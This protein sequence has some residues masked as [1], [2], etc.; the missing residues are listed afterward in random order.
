MLRRVGAVCM[1]YLMVQ[2]RLLIHDYGY[3]GSWHYC[4]GSPLTGSLT[5]GVK[6]V[7]AGLGGPR[8]PEKYLR[9]A[10]DRS[11]GESALCETGVLCPDSSGRDPNQSEH[12]P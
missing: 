12:A 8:S 6:A 10:V 2:S 5:T 7:G 4:H 3:I 11:N 9:L 1:Q